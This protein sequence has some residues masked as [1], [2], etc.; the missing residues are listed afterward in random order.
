MK[1]IYI[2]IAAAAF[3]MTTGCAMEKNTATNTAAGTPTTVIPV[4]TPPTN[5]GTGT[6]TS[7][8]SGST[9]TLAATG[10]AMRQ[11][12]YNKLPSDPQNIKINIDLS[13]S[14]DSVIISYTFNGVAQEAAFGGKHPYNI[15]VSGS[16]QSGWTTYNSKPVWKGFFQDQ[17][18]AIVVVIDQTIN[19]GDGSPAAFVGGRV[20]FM[21]FNQYWPNNPFQGPEKMCWEISYGPYD[22]RTF[23]VGDT[24]DFSSSLNPQNAGPIQTEEGRYYQLLGSFTGLSRVDS[25]L[26]DF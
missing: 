24:I 9:V 15:N 23:L 17:W 20:Y 2:A 10:S 11:M 5:T 7:Y 14:S 19:T 6:G 21:N 25:G 12:F 18:G 8:T 4:P 1:T 16:K 3:L 13:R 26:P 22:C